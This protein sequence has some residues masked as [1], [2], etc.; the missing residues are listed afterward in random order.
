MAIRDHAISLMISMVGRGLGERQHGRWATTDH[1]ITIS[2]VIGLLGATAA[3][4]T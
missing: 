1:G 4:S 2:M 3:A